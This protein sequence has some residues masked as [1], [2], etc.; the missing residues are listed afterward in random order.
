MRSE[1]HLNFEM[2]YLPTLLDFYQQI[3]NLERKLPS[4]ASVCKAVKPFS[5]S[6]ND[7]EFWVAWNFFFSNIFSDVEIQDTQKSLLWRNTGSSRQRRVLLS[8]FAR[9]SGEGNGKPQYNYL[10]RSKCINA[11]IKMPFAIILLPCRSILWHSQ[12]SSRVLG[13]SG[14][15][16]HFSSLGPAAAHTLFTGYT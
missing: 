1:K 5:V 14:G 15:S 8:H 4:D 12:I 11:I 2:W 7:L 10:C 6:H 9:G 3:S 13:S 16:P